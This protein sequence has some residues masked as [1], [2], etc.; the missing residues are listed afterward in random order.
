MRWW[1]DPVFKS[2]YGAL[3]GVLYRVVSLFISWIC[4]FLILLP[5][6]TPFPKKPLL[7]GTFSSV[8]AKCNVLSQSAFVGIYCRFCNV[9]F[10][11][12]QSL[13][14]HFPAV[15]F[16]WKIQLR[17]SAGDKKRNDFVLMV[18][19]FKVMKVAFLTLETSRFWHHKTQLGFYCH[20]EGWT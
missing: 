7:N 6:E 16:R 10:Y 11:S 14:L 1:L 15:L 8:A 4:F 9:N 20:H 5:N 13:S 3:N 19:E 17:V 12:H 2:L 18:R